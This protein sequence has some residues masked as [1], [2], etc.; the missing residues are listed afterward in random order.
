M[1]AALVKEARWERVLSSEKNAG[2]GP[3]DA[4]ERPPHAGGGGERART[5]WPSTH[6]PSHG[7]LSSTAF[8]C[9]SAEQLRPQAPMLKLWRRRMCLFIAYVTAVAILSLTTGTTA[10]DT[11]PHPPRGHPQPAPHCLPPP[12]YHISISDYIRRLAPRRARAA[13]R[14]AAPPTGLCPS[15]P[16]GGRPAYQAAAEMKDQGRTKS[17]RGRTAVS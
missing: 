2:I 10:C 6:A 8:R 1:R 14:A 12:T 7:S 16:P 11:W 5:A 17:K 4:S 15:E 13:C 9:L 3:S